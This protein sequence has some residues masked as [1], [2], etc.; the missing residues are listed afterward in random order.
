[1]HDDAYC[2]AGVC[3]FAAAFDMWCLVVNMCLA[4]GVYVFGLNLCAV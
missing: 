1:M 2:A 3:V 4:Y